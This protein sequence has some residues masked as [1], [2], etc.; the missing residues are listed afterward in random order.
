MQVLLLSTLFILATAL[1]YRDLGLCVNCPSRAAVCYHKDSFV[2]ISSP[3]T[4]IGANSVSFPL[5]KQENA[6]A[7]SR[8]V[9]SWFAPALAACR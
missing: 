1:A 5:C 7:T 9:E 2:N 4:I 3:V 8:Q 6:A